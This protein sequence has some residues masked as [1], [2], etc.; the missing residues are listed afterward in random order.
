MNI[1]YF[2][3]IIALSLFVFSCKES[4][5]EEVKEEKKAIPQGQVQADISIFQ[6][7]ASFAWKNMTE[8]DD[9]KI[10]FTK[11]LLDEISYMPKYDIMKHTKL[12]EMCKALKAKRY[13]EEGI[14]VSASIDQY[15]ASTDSLLSAVK[16]FVVATPNVENYPLVNDL[17]KDITALENDVVTHRVVYDSWVQRYNQLLDEQKD[18]LASFGE[19]YASLKKKGMFQLE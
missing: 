4:P 12:M 10:A 14:L 19:P 8:A 9:Q 11:R 18:A 1:K 5:K 2:S 16:V 3:F 17:L 15:D 7:S 6:D 13:S